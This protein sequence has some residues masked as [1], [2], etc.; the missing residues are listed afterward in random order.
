M[1][2]EDFLAANKAVSQL[3]EKL[4]QYYPTHEFSEQANIIG[5]VLT[6]IRDEVVFSMALQ[7]EAALL[8]ADD[9]GLVVKEPKF[10]V[11]VVCNGDINS[12]ELLRKMMCKKVATEI[13]DA[14]GVAHNFTATISKRPMADQ[15]FI[16]GFDLVQ[17]K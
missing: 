8:V 16:I 14:D 4:R 5:T 9:S 6:T 17:I 1:K 7:V 2:Y 15:R 10:S 12:D 13:A 3:Q 11:E